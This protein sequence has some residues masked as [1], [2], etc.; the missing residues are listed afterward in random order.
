MS[1]TGRTLT[2]T[3]EI[4]PRQHDLFGLDL[5]EGPPRG[6]LIFGLLIFGVWLALTVPVSVL[7]AGG[8]SPNS[9]LLFVAPP[10]AVVVL[11]WRKTDENPRRR[12]VTEWVLALRYIASGHEPIV[13]LG[14]NTARRH[15]ARLR[16]RIAARFGNGDLLAVAIPTRI[17]ENRSRKPA[18]P[19]Q[20]PAV[21]VRATVRTYGTDYTERVV[22]NEKRG[23]RAA[24]SR[25]KQAKEQSV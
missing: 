6:Q 22:K 12:K 5:G 15:G 25:R 24:V 11:G 17:H 21:H 1:R 14:R 18:K 8:P 2:R 13:T 10:A 3:I 4:E 19:R 20:D 16:D 7:L 9:A 23:R